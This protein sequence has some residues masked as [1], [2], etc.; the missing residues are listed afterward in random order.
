MTLRAGVIGLGAI[1]GGIASNLCKA[2]IPTTVCDVVPELVAKHEGEGAKA[3]AS[4]GALAAAVDVVSVVVRDRDVDAVM[5]EV[6]EHAGAGSTI[7][8]HST[9][10]PETSKRLG[11]QAAERGLSYLE[12][13]VTGGATG[14]AAGT[15]G[16]IVGGE[17]DV[18]ARCRP[19][20]EPAAGEIVHAGELGAG[21]VVKLSINLLGYMTFLAGHEAN[22]LATSAG[23]SLEAFDQAGEAGGQ[24]TPYLKAFLALHRGPDHED[25]AFQQMAEG[26]TELAQKD[27]KL[28]LQ[29][30]DDVGIGL[31]GA[32]L[33]RQLMPRVYGLIDPKR[34]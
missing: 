20:F 29:L 27:L 16:Y 9:V 4:P 19:V 24:V 13:P 6:M 25:P 34:R 8:G 28:A 23:V 14:A 15:L 18:L 11:A 17:A 7:V 21:S 30:A 5:A 2:G 31:P 32:A 10:H 22:L 33:T 3:A 12:V 1:G 26:I